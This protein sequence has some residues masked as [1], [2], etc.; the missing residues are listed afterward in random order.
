MK[1]NRSQGGEEEDRGELTEVPRGST[2]GWLGG[3]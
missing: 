3:T 2:E 1:I